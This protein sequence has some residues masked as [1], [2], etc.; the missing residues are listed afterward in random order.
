MFAWYVCEVGKKVTINEIVLKMFSCR[1]FKVFP[2]V[3]Y[4]ISLANLIPVNCVIG[5]Y[6]TCI[7]GGVF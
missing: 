3:P 1:F 2:S 7:S 4:V 6:N 5:F